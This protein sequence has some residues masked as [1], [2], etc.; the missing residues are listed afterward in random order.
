M[1][2]FKGFMLTIPRRTYVGVAQAIAKQ[3]VKLRFADREWSGVYN[4][5]PSNIWDCAKR[6]TSG[7]YVHGQYQCVSFHAAKILADMQGGA[8]LHDNRDFDKWARKA[9][10]D[11]RT[12]GVPSPEDKDII[13]GMHCM[14]SADV[15]TRLHTR[16]VSHSF[17]K[18]NPD[19]CYPGF[20]EKEYSDLSE[21]AC[22]KPYHAR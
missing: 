12:E 5:W 8:I 16:L 22:F 19:Q 11:G 4:L 15:A 14:M 1:G 7:M 21:L 10:F 20:L 18:H 13:L 3:G 6:F 17:P 9:R 2:S